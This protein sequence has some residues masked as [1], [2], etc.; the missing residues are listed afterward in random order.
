MPLTAENSS[1]RNINLA[2]L[3]YLCH[4]M[5]EIVIRNQFFI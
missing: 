5:G 4:N 3:R 1:T 2:D